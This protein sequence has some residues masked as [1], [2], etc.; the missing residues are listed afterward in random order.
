MKAK[1]DAPR[2]HQG[3]LRLRETPRITALFKRVDWL[4]KAIFGVKAE[5]LEP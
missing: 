2:S 4:E 1:D 5:E 3:T